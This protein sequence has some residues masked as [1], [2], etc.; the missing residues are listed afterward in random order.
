MQAVHT[1]Q[2]DNKLRYYIKWSRSMGIGDTGWIF[3]RVN[4][5]STTAGST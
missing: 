1:T 5:R 4:P 3:L 2:S